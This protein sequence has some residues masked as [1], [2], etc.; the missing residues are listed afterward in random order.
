MRRAL[1]RISMTV[2]C[3]LSS[4]KNGASARRP[5]A[6]CSFGH[7]C[8]LSLPV[9]S[10]RASMPASAASRRLV[11]SR[12][13]ISIE[14]N[15]TGLRATSAQC[16]AA[17]SASEVLPWPGRAAS[18]LSV[19]GCRPSS[20]S[21]RSWK[22]VGHAGDRRSRGRRAL[23]AARASASSTGYSGTSES[24]TRFS[25]T[26][27]I[28]D[29]ARSSVSSTSSSTSIRHVLDVGRGL[30]ELPQHRQLGDDVGVVRGV[31]RRRRG[32]L[33]AQQRRPAAER[34]ELAAAPQLLGDRDRVDG[35]AAAVQHVAPRRT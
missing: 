12:W 25:A 4:M 24:E 35:L 23:R 16:S 9:E 18:T 28:I 29:S 19:D 6:W 15:S 17:P 10:L 11:S 13:P 20:R 27:K 32:G 1:A 7:S 34:F 26:S 2:Q 30:D 3:G 31:G 5:T 14:K 8:S 33:D 22:P 21:S